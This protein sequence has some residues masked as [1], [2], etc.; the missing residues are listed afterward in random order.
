MPSSEKQK[1]HYRRRFA[2]YQELCDRYRQKPR[3]SHEWYPHYK[4]LRETDEFR[5]LSREE[6]FA[7]W[8]ERLTDQEI[9][10]CASAI[11]TLVREDEGRFQE[12]VAA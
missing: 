4:A 10:E 6:H 1:A 9:W 12:G 11:D 5:R 2:H 7:F 8:R 3:G